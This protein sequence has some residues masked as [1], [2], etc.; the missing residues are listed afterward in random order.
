[1]QEHQMRVV[2]EGPVFSVETLEYEDPER[3]PVRKD[4]VR[5]PGAVLVIAVTEAG[6]LLMIRNQR[7]SVDRWLLEFCAGKLEPGEPPEQAARREL[8]EECG[9]EAG[10]L[11]PI[12]S[13]L[14][15]P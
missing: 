5:H 10:A 7:V 4:I 2:H 3:G 13:F 12:G 1:M 9:R 6:K 15:S 8:V 14:T 11:V